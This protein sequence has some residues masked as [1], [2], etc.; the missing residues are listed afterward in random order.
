MNLAIKD[1]R[2]HR[3]RFLSSTV[4]VGLILMVV[5]TIGGIIRGIILDSSTIIEET[6]ADLWVV[7]RNWLGP[8]VEI[9]RF[10]EDYY[11][12]IQAIHGVAEASPLVMAWDHVERPMA[13]TPLMKFMYMNTVI[14]TRTMVKPGWIEMPHDLRFIVIGYEPAHIGGPPVIVAG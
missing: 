4:G 14:G 9:S 3:F 6:G 10:P 1:T 12:A 8:F 2:Y 5:L 11:H 13:P 7:Q